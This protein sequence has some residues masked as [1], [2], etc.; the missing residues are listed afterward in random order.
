MA[1]HLPSGTPRTRCATLPRHVNSSLPSS[2]SVAEPRRGEIWQALTPGQPSDPHQPRF[3]LVVSADARNRARGHVI[4]VPI[5]SAG[6]L[7]PTRLPIPAE[8]TGLRYESVLFCEELNTI[9]KA[10]LEGDRPRGRASSDL[11]DAVVIAVR[12]AT[13]DYS[14]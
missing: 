12:R 13:G 4:V 1:P 6:N 11:L 5:F 9:D 2:R 8:G 14:A 7:G 3:V 10:F